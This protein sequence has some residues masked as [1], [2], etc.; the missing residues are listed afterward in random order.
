MSILRAKTPKKKVPKDKNK[1]SVQAHLHPDVYKEFNAIAK[2]KQWSMKKLN[3]N[4]ILEY[5]EQH[6]KQKA[7]E[8]KPKQ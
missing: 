8:P 4:I 1:I 5:L 7:A 6:R 3:E 2:A